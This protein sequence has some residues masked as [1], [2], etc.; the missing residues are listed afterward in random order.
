MDGT[1]AALSALAAGGG[2]AGEL[3]Q[4]IHGQAALLVDGR[5][6][7]DDQLSSILWHLSRH[8]LTGTRAEVFETRVFNM[9]D[10]KVGTALSRI[11]A[12]GDH[13]QWQEIEA[14]AKTTELASA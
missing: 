5:S 4:A 1:L 14:W 9:T 6:L 11:R 3:I 12:T 7:Q 8:I 13:R 10:D 2:T